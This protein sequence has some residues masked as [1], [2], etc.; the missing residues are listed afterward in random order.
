MIF[1]LQFIAVLLVCVLLV[2]GG[3]ILT[4]LVRDIKRMSKSRGINKK[5][6]FS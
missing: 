3:Y 1:T 5:D 4:P 2:T 6:F